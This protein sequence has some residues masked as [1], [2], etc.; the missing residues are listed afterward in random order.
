MWFVTIPILISFVLLILL[1]YYLYK[2]S[3]LVQYYVNRMI[4]VSNFIHENVTEVSTH[5]YK[6][7]EFKQYLLKHENAT[8]LLIWIHGGAFIKAEPDSILPYIGMI[9]DEL[10]EFDILVFDYPVIYNFTLFHTLEYI[11]E[12]IEKYAKKDK[13]QNF[14]MGGDS[15][16]IFYALVLLNI[17]KSLSYAQ[18]ANL[19]PLNIN[20][21][22]LISACGFF[23][24]NQNELFKKVFKFYVGRGVQNLTHL[25][26]NLIQIPSLLIT[27]VNDFVYNQNV[28]FHR[29]NPSTTT[30]QVFEKNDTLLHNFMSYTG[31]PETMESV[32]M[33][34]NF[35]DQTLTPQF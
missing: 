8:N 23:H 14:I 15:A 30:L 6:N 11:H 28:K 5:V 32:K 3:P 13:Y 9:Y 19:K 10:H 17:E 18:Q 21:K 4:P 34:K 20:Y 2:P 35:V 33:I 7:K 22:C 16:G 1:I 25:S 27:S 31:L 26:V 29:N 12:T 24:S